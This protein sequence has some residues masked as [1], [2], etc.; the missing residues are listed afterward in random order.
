MHTHTPNNKSL[1]HAHTHTHTYI[2]TY[3]HSL[4]LAYYLSDYFSF[5]CFFVFF[6]FVP[7]TGHIHSFLVWHYGERICAGTLQAL[8]VNAATFAFYLHVDLLPAPVFPC[9]GSWVSAVR[10][11]SH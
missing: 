6:N 4:L 9:C 3:T 8:M 11:V 10:M 7:N 5:N 2:H 1:S